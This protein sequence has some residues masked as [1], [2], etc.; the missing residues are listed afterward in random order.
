[1]LLLARW[2]DIDLAQARQLFDSALDEIQNYPALVFLAIAVLPSLVI[3]V[4]PLLLLGGVVF[5]NLY[6][7]IPG[8]LLTMAAIVTNTLWTYPVARYLLRHPLESFLRWLGYR[9]PTLPPGGTMSFVLIVRLTP[10]VPLCFQ[11]YL[12]GVM[13]VSFHAYFWVGAAQQ[14]A[15]AAA[16][17]LTGGAFIEGDGGIIV[18]AVA[19]LVVVV[20]ILN[21]LR[22][23]YLGNK[24]LNLK[25]V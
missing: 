23:K 24:R 17:A 9:I 7:I 20:I 22:K 5:G 3:P 6:G 19:F 2:L 12:L 21:M 4:T 8:T 25:D 1:M 15:F 13:Q 14:S 16:I 11:N 10:G 18:S